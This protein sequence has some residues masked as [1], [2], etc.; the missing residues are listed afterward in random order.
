[1]VLKPCIDNIM[2]NWIKT[3]LAKP[4]SP[5]TL[6]GILADALRAEGY[7]CRAV[8]DE[9]FLESGLV[10]SVEYL[11][12]Q[13]INDTAMRTSSKIVCRHPVHF[14]DGL[15]EFQHA[16]GSSEE[17]SLLNGFRSWAQTDLATLED[18]VTGGQK[19]CLLLEMSL[20][21][22]DGK[23]ELK[24]KIFMGPYIH[25]VAAPTEEIADCE[26]DCHDFCPCCLLTESMDAFQEQIGS[27]AFVGI[28]LYVCRDQQGAIAADC[29]INGE[30]H[31]LGV[32]HLTRYAASWPQRGFEI[33]KQ[34]VAIRTLA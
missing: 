11:D 28:R 34:Y 10:A 33:R 7:A 22:E 31:P 9:V 13:V 4:E 8:N 15:F 1:V 27:R 12:Q 18:A 14:P 25:N 23:H 26:G 29:R 20:P 30:D 2:L 17:E 21:S 32:E 6:A 5:T 3:L 16:S 19:S 24:R